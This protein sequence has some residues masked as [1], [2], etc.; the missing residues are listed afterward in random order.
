MFRSFDEGRAGDVGRNRAPELQFAE[1]M[2]PFIQN[3]KRRVLSGEITPEAGGRALKTAESA[4][5]QSYKEAT[6]ALA[7]ELQ[8]LSTL[9]E[10]VGK[11]LSGLSDITPALSGL[12]GSLESLVKPSQSVSD[13][14][15]KVETSST[16][17]PRSLASA[18]DAASGFA[19]RVNGLEIKQ[20]SIPSF[21]PQ[22][23]T[24]PA[25]FG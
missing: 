8:K 23:S 7:Q 5:P 1:L 11:S 19:S 22:G 3:T 10:P 20:I 12:S 2:K 25:S 13:V 4:Y 6:G 16:G 21:A 9:A 18:G 15:T 17:L 24:I 14:F